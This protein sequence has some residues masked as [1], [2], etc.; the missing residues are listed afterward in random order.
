MTYGEA[1]ISLPWL[2][3]RWGDSFEM[4]DVKVATEDVYQVAVTLRKR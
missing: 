2:R 4:L 3:E 1:V